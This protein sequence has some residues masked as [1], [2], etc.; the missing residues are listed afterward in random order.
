MGKAV[1]QTVIGIYTL[2][3]QM[4]FSVTLSIVLCNHNLS[5]PLPLARS[6]FFVAHLIMS[7]RFIL[8]NPF[9]SWCFFCLSSRAAMNYFC[10]CG[11]SWLLTLCLHVQH[12]LAADGPY[13]TSSWGWGGGISLDQTLLINYAASS[14]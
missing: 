10:G 13:S 4:P 5:L 12:D 9:S 14:H 8:I 6:L 1:W 11:A 2:P 7:Q 3:T